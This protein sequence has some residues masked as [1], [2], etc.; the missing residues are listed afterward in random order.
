MKVCKRGT[1][2]PL[3]VYERVPFLSKLYTKG[4]G[5]GLEVEPPR[6][7]LREN[8]PTHPG[9]GLNMPCRFLHTYIHSKMKKGN[10][11]GGLNFKI[12]IKL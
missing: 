5:L 8:P 12:S 2:F 7:E 9:R 4:N 6:I 10:C 3:K 11:I 1:F